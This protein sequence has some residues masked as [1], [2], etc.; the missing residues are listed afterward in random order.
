ME[1]GGE[2]TFQ[3][4]ER[5][6]IDRCAEV[7]GGEIFMFLSGHEEGEEDE[8]EGTG[9]PGDTQRRDSPEEARR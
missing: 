8:A 1:R 9:N 2:E 5:T 7:R 3:H 4:C 6:S